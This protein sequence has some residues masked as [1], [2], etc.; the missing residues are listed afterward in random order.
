MELVYF[1]ITYYDNK[2]W[3][4]IDNDFKANIIIGIFHLIVVGL[5]LKEIWSNNSTEKNKRTE[6]T[7]MILILGIIGMWIWIPKNIKEKVVD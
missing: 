2:L 7:F 6:N 4:L 3:I 5:F 1:S